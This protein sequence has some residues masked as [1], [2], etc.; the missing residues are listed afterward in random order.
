MASYVLE[1]NTWSIAKSHIQFALGRQAFHLGRLEDAVTYFS[2]VLTDTKQTPQQQVA[3]IREFLFIY[4]QYT[5]QEGI[6][7]LKESLPHLALPV[8]E[9]KDIQ[10]TLSNEQSNTTHREEWAT[11]E[12]ELLEESIKNGYISSS[13]KA[14]AVQQQDDRR[15]VCAVGEPAIVHVELYNPLQVAISLSNI[16]LGCGYRSSTEAISE[17]TTADAYQVM[18]DCSKQNK[19]SADMFDFDEFEL[20]KIDEITLDPLEKKM[21]SNK[22]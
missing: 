13:K 15:V 8:I 22:S 14:L 3:H 17:S 11:M 5:I 19:E 9:D 18:P 16:I 7:P 1:E 10:V 2:N 6:D 12:M 4:K 20:Q 21:A